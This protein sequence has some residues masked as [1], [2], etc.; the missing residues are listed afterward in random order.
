MKL[1]EILTKE[2]LGIIVGSLLG[3]SSIPKKLKNQG[4]HYIDITHS[5][6]QLDYLK[7]KIHI[8]E[9]YGFK[10]SNIYKRKVKTYIEY[11]VHIYYP[12]N[13]NVINAL[14]WWFYNNGKKYFT[15]KMLNYL[16]PLGMAIWF[17]DDGSKAIHYNKNHTNIKSRE[18]YIST[19]MS[20]TEHCSIIKFFNKLGIVCKERKDRDKFRLAMNS[21]NA[22]KFISI[23]SPF[24]C[25]S[26]QYKI[27][28]QYK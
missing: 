1:I 15:Y 18:L 20:K 16:T 25:S 2:Q 11:S 21:T 6:K 8:F 5:E 12:Q 10:V 23:I 28:L 26:M 7:Y 14:R 3:D 17:M 19:Y 24:I 4:N 22:K 13:P 27:D 9:K